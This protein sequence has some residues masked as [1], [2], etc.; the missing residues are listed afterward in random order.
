MSDTNCMLSVLRESAGETP[1]YN[2]KERTEKSMFGTIY[3]ELCIVIDVSV[4]DG[5]VGDTAGT[6]RC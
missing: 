4:A 5:A 2:S 1:D 6:I 3:A